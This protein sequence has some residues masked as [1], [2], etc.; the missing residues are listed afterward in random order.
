M[1]IS[2]IQQ[3]NYQS[4]ITQAKN[5]VNETKKYAPLA[6]IDPN[7]QY[8]TIDD[9]ANDLFAMQ[10]KLEKQYRE[11]TADSQV[12]TVEDLKKEIAEFFPEF[13]MV[14][15]KPRSVT[16]GKNLLYIDETNLQKMVNDPSYKADVYALMKR[17]LS[18]TNGYCINGTAWKL[19]GTVF[20]LSEDND[21]EGGIPYL[22]MCKGAKVEDPHTFL[23][24]NQ[25]NSLFSIHKNKTKST[26]TAI[27]DKQKK[28]KQFNETWEKERAKRQELREQIQQEALKKHITEEEIIKTQ[29]ERKQNYQEWAAQKYEQQLKYEL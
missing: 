19:T 10:A 13:T 2:S 1:G 17:E 14:S 20:T 29:A 6:S 16:E 11:R 24:E 4:S 26:K 3:N 18:S 7:K 9:Y 25:R 8:S 21:K 27:K 12:H 22:G 5:T 23:A 28:T 15:S